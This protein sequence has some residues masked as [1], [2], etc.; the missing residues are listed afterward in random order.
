M[1]SMPIRK[2]IT[3]SGVSWGYYLNRPGSTRACRQQI[4]AWGFATKK[5]AVDAEAA[6]RLELQ[7]ESSARQRGVT[8]EVPATLRELIARFFEEHTGLAPKTAERYRDHAE[9]LSAELRNLAISDV[10]TLRLTQEW[11]RLARE[12]GHHR[13]TKAVRPLSAKSVRNIAGFL[14]SVYA[15]AMEWGI[16]LTNP[17]TASAKPKGQQGRES[18]AFAPDQMRTFIAAS[19]HRVVPDVLEIAAATGA[20]RG[21]VLALRWQ[22]IVNGEAAICRSMSQVRGRVFIKEPKTRSGRRIVALPA[23]ALEILAGIRQKQDVYRLEYGADYRTDLDLIFCETNGEPLRPDSISSSVS[24]LRKRLG[25]PKGANLH[26]LRHSHGSQLLA[27]GVDIPT[28]SARLG[29]ASPATT[30]KIY[31]HTLKGRDAKAAEMW[32]RF[33]R[34]GKDSTET[35]PF[36]TVG[37]IQ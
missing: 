16:V 18:V 7:A 26:A 3:K 20:R 30:L 10:T 11:A 37:V 24:A 28:V 36:E 27:A 23:S 4:T 1:T 9:A 31:A 19:V 14:S 35:A 5:A 32:E 6:R 22:D 33:Q 21:E 29:H 12:G 15:K 2:R 17:V 25:L 13:R 8:G 34:A